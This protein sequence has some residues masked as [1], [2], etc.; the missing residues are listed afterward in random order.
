MYPFA[1]QAGFFIILFLLV[2]RVESQVYKKLKKKE[3]VCQVKTCILY[4]LAVFFLKV[5]DFLLYFL[6][7]FIVTNDIQKAVHI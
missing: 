5:S 6:I 4:Q 1:F 2:K 7:H 3:T